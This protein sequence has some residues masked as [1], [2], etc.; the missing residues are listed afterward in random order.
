[1]EIKVAMRHHS[2]PSE[3]PE[4]KHPIVSI[5]ESMQDTG[6]SNTDSR[7]NVSRNNMENSLK[8][9]FK[10][11]DI[12]ILWPPFPLLGIQ[13]TI[14]AYMCYSWDKIKNVHGNIIHN[15]KNLETAQRP[16]GEK[17]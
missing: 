9:S 16:V 10:F 4:W 3:W 2:I 5:F 13:S 14:N 8:L 15:I 17:W 1:M 12:Y 6:N 11:E 7:S